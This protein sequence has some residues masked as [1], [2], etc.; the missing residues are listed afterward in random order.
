MSRITFPR[1]TGQQVNMRIGS[2]RI[3]DASSRIEARRL[4]EALPAALEAAIAGRAI[5]IARR[6]TA[7]ELAIRIIE[8]VHQVQERQP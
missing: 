5:P 3:V 4:A 8:A 2:L 7:D 6:S 1:Q